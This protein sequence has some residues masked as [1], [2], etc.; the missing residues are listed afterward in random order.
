MKKIFI[1]LTVLIAFILGFKFITNDYV[2]NEALRYCET[3]KYL[4][5]LSKNIVN[6][7][8]KFKMSIKHEPH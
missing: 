7:A 6:I 3:S 1:L 8:C 2:L 4:Q 5:P